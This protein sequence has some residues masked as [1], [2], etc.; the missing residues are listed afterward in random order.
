MITIDRDE[1]VSMLPPLVLGH[2][3]LSP[4]IK[5]YWQFYGLD[6]ATADISQTIGLVDS[7]PYQICCNVFQPAQPVGTCFVVH[8][9][10]DHGGLYRHVIKHLL[11][12][13]LAVVMIDLPGHGLSSGA[14][15]D[16]DDFF[17]YEQ[18]W[19]AVLD[20]CAALPRP[21]YAVGQSTG[22][23][24]IMLNI[25]KNPTNNLAKV[26]M[27]APLVRPRK[28]LQTRL[29]QPLI[30]L[31]KPVI[32]R[33]FSH[34]SQ[35][36]RFLAFVKNDDPL[37]SRELPASWL[38]AMGEWVQWFLSQQRIIAD[39]LVLQGDADRTVD[40]KFNLKALTKRVS[41]ISVC[42]YATVRHHMVNELPAL[43]AQMFADMENFLLDGNSANEHE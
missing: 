9:Y 42:R 39:V 40:A 16:I 10:F 17:S 4:V 35:D 24:V 20:A 11:S 7:D 23:S 1:I 29:V 5:D 25:V 21:W 12:M 19:Q 32:P 27:F 37:Q 28:W 30:S 8:G 36:T 13:N 14:R 22:C 34:N 3:I 41:N 31:F 18:T 38:S 26:V 43:R 6:L 2:R 33:Y 15:A